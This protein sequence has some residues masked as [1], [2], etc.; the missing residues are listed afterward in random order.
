MAIK[1]I[2]QIHR[3]TS[4]R[5]QHWSKPKNA[6]IQHFLQ[7]TS[8]PMDLDKY[9]DFPIRRS[10]LP[11]DPPP[12]FW[13]TGKPPRPT[14]TIIGRTIIRLRQPNTHKS[15][16]AGFGSAIDGG[17]RC[18]RSKHLTAREHPLS[19]Q[20]FEPLIIHPTPPHLG[21]KPI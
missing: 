12:H 18:Q 21:R 3:K 8:S 16:L 5:I 4:Q 7:L 17:V 10:I 1:R 6:Q 13:P 20:A 9:R 14:A 2:S 19:P 15:F 11:S